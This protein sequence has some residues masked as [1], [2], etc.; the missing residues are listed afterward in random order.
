[1]EDIEKKSF[2]PSSIE[3]YI[4]CNLWKFLPRILPNEFQMKI[5]ENGTKEHLRLEHENFH[6]SEIMCK[7]YFTKV[8]ERCEYFFKEQHICVDIAGEFLE[9]TPDVYGFEPQT[10]TVYVLDYKTGRRTVLAENNVQLLAYAFLVS[11]NHPDWDVENLV[12]AILNTASDN[13]NISRYPY[14]AK[15]YLA[16]LEEHIEKAVKKNRNQKAFGLKGDWCQFCPSKIYCPLQKGLQKLKDYVDLDTD[17]LILEARSRKSEIEEREKNVKNGEYSPT[18]SPFVEQREKRSWSNKKIL[19]DKFFVRKP[20]S[21]GEAEKLFPQE[22]VEGLVS[23][24]K[25]SILRSTC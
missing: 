3:R 22:E 11:K 10:K 25:Y 20:M 1:M 15:K 4:R 6:D 9:G 2:R 16:T 5:M 13:V 12:L 17:H 19:P 18:L 21:V 7:E 24:N 8:K 23:K 14:S